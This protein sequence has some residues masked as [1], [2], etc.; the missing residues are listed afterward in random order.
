MQKNYI[1]QL[2]EILNATGWPQVEL[3]KELGVTFAAL[4]R[5]INKKASPRPSALKSIRDLYKEKVGSLPLPKEVIKKTLRELDREKSRHG[6]VRKIIKENKALREDLLLELTYNS[7]AI[8]GNTLT[9]KETE[10]I[11]FDKGRIPDKTY[12]EHLEAT[13][14][15]AAVNMIFDGEFDGPITGTTIK[16]LHRVI[17]QGISADA[18]KYS[19]HHR[20]IRG[21][22]LALPAPEDIQEEMDG[23]LKNIN[24]PKTHIIE[25]SAK[26]H[27]AF[28]AIHPFGDGNGRVGRLIMIIQFLKA[29]YAPCLIENSRKSEYYEYLE[30]AQ[31]RSEGHLIKFLAET[32]IR[33]F[34]LIKKHKK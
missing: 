1:E 3:A 11:I 8:E 20:A 5:W 16:D 24:R 32:V 7:N 21:V 34:Q 33:G 10:T 22:D 14:H 30:L 25:Y 12:V 18:G 28:E 27:A 26:T 9:K 4:N 13:N 6:N 15:A 19:K 23:L 29:G 2:K 17:L 31:K